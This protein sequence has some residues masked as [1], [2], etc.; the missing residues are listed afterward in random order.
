MCCQ[1]LKNVEV[2][3]CRSKFPER[4]ASR[5]AEY[6]RL[7]IPPSLVNSSALN[8]PRGIRRQVLKSF[9]HFKMKS[10]V[11]ATLASLSCIVLAAPS[12]ISKRNSC[13]SGSTFAIGA[14]SPFLLTPISKAQPD[15]A[16][17]GVSTGVTTPNDLC[18]IVN[19]EIPDFIDGESTLLKTC[20]LSFAFPTSQ[21][22]AP[23]TLESSGP[24]HFTFTGYLT[25]FG[26]DDKTTYNR[27]PLLG[28][29][30][31]FP[32]ES[33]VPGNTYT[34]ATLPCGILP[35]TGGQTVAGALCSRDTSLKWSQTGPSGNG[36][37]PVGF[38][39]VVS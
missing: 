1:R 32:P 35:G 27:Q 24:G 19:L 12:Q 30:P 10:T 13:P 8:K 28:P 22:A 5:L 16:F 31:P 36:G 7:S 38:F 18:T 25:G 37:C 3:I 4:V 15:K 23:H 26:S 9:Q 21:Q 20:T 34:I 29:S 33:M 39:V 14:I 17:G 6:K 2:W 11:V